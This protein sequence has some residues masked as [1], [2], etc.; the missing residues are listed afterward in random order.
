MT[1]LSVAKDVAK[2]VGVAVP[3]E[4]F[5]STRREH[6]EM[7]FVIQEVADE[8]LKAHEW[9]LLRTLKTMTGDGTTTQFA[10]PS[11]Y[12]RMLKDSKMWASN[13]ETP[14]TH[15]T[16]TD[17]WLEMEVRDYD[18][19]I[20]A[21]TIL[22]GNVEI[23]PATASGETV[24]YY[25]LSN[26]IFAPAS[27]SNVATATADTDT[28]RLNEKTLRQ[29]VIARWKMNKGQAYAED[30][31]KFETMMGQDISRDK[32]ARMIKVGRPRMPRDVSIAYPQ[33][34]TP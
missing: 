19:V 15:I 13:F 26:L 4:L 3:S 25:Y 18:Y 5:A 21:W 24:Q 23:K 27:G 10:L 28:F 16:S 14:L 32:G 1:V 6:V 12:D 2:L 29:G 7:A 30:L 17:Q 20:G 33:N 11:D 22:G 31:A 9:T 8:I 34:I